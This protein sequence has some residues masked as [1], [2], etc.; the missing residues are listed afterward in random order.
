MKKYYIAQQATDGSRMHVHCMLDT[1]G[2]KHIL[3]IYNTYCISTAKLFTQTHL[4]VM[5]DVHCL[6]C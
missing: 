5:V 2:Y 6:S 1:E 4:S 3:R